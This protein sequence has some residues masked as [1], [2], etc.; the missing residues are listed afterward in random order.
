MQFL[1]QKVMQP[2]EAHANRWAVARLE[3]D[4][5]QIELYSTHSTK[6]GAQA[7]ISLYMKK[8]AYED[9]RDI[10][11]SLALARLSP[12]YQDVLALLFKLEATRSMDEK[13]DRVRRH[14]I[15]GDEKAGAEAFFEFLETFSPEARKSSWQITYPQ[16][17]PLL[18]GCYCALEAAGLSEYPGDNK[19]EVLDLHAPKYTEPPSPITKRPAEASFEAPTEAP[20]GRCNWIDDALIV[21][22]A[23][24]SYT[25]Y[26]GILDDLL[27]AALVRLHTD[28]E[29]K[30]MFPYWK[31]GGREE[32]ILR[33]VTL[34]SF[35]IP[36][37]GT[38]SDG[39][40]EAFVDA[41]LLFVSLHPGEPIYM[42]CV[43]GVGR[44]GT[45]AAVYLGK[46]HRLTAEE[47]LR[48]VDEGFKSRPTKWGKNKAA[49]RTSPET[50][51]Q[52]AQVTRI[53]SKMS[54]K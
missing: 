28:D 26:R 5:T 44:A 1:Y 33:H 10:I 19:F 45:V 36:N 3:C 38:V 12:Q 41:L 29:T 8:E 52:R 47:A 18:K 6:E 30:G 2:P 50:D 35:P 25:E 48:R 42:H 11:G 27:P 53:L 23:P 49:S 20:H 51:E 15:A 14:W 37:G 9:H 22:G 24:S 39:L 17:A 4:V 46:R 32:A 16:F 54:A 40:L 31:N 13:I 7:A 43:G 34:F 21:G